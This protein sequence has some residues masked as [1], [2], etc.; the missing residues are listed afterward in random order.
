MTLDLRIST[1]EHCMR[2][3]DLYVSKAG[4]FMETLEEAQIYLLACLFI[5]CK[6]NEI[7]PPTVT[8]FEYVSKYKASSKEFI[9]LEV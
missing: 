6:Y 8:D 3:F 4:K 7:Y 5:S 1:I 9:L 2:L